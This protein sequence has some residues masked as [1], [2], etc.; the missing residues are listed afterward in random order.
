MVSQ[1]E[2]EFKVPL[3]HQEKMDHQDL[4][5]LNLEGLP[6]PGG[7]RALVLNLKVLKYST[8]GS[9]EGHSTPRKE[10]EPITSAYP[11]TQSTA[12]H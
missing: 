2:M 4:P 5:D 10:V 11:R 9:L 7:G 1:G 6:T 8:Q 12:L 3:D